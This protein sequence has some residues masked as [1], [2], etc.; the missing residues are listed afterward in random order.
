L[1]LGRAPDIMRERTRSDH[2]WSALRGSQQVVDAF[3]RTQNRIRVDST[4]P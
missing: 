2:F 3:N 4:L 1:L